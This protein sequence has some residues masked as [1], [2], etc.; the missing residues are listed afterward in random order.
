M[1]LL[2]LTN[3]KPVLKSKKI[4]CILIYVSSRRPFERCAMPVV[5][6]GGKSEDNV[7]AELWVDVLRS[8]LSHARPLVRPVCVVAEDL[9]LPEV[10]R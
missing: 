6:Y 10:V 4:L 3:S 2:T 1:F 8:E 9:G 5:V 7:S